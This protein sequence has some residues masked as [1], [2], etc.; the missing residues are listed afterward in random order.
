M[1]RSCLLYYMKLKRFFFG[2]CFAALFLC[3][4]LYADEAGALRGNSAA[5]DE[6]SVAGGRVFCKKYIDA[7]GRLRVHSFSDETEELFTLNQSGA[8]KKRVLTFYSDGKVRRCFYNADYRLER[9]EI[10]NSGKKSADA[11]IQKLCRY[12]YNSEDGFSKTKREYDASGK[13]MTETL[14]AKNGAGDVDVA[15][16]TDIIIQN[17]YDFP[18]ADS[19]LKTAENLLNEK[20]R[21]ARSFRRTFDGHGRILSEEEIRFRYAA[22]SPFAAEKKTV[23]KNVYDYRGSDEFP[24]VTFYEDGVLRMR[25]LYSSE[26]E[27]VRYVYFD[28]D[29]V[30]KLRYVNG[31]KTEETVYRERGIQ[32]GYGEKTE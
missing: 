8:S 27:Y 17:D 3:A 11:Y 24:A 1:P 29:M 13:K 4:A 21:L 28:S 25:T 10:W 20:P 7:S 15:D 32:S 30:M 18:G 31:Q 12:E 5:P 16:V 6:S 26:N 2:H 14:Y 22:E 19:S 23:R 9:T